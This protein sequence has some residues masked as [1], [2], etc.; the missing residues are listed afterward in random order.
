MFNNS[1]REMQFKI[2]HRII[3]VNKAL[4][5]FGLACSPLCEFCHIYSQSI[6]H[7]FC[8][9]FI[10]KTFW[11]AVCKDL[12]DL[13]LIRDNLSDK[14]IL[15]GYGIEGDEDNLTLNQIIMFGKKFIFDCK[16]NVGKL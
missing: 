13:N 12:R 10:I 2:I 9:C 16:K 5:R 11:M 14:D 8:N 15:L 3:G 7:L 1:L 6:E 4:Y